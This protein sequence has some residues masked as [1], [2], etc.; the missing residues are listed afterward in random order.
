[1]EP[2]SYRR[3]SLHAAGRPARQHV[4]GYAAREASYLS[5]RL[6]DAQCG[7]SSIRAGHDFDATRVEVEASVF[8]AGVRGTGYRGTRSSDVGCRSRG[9]VTDIRIG[10]EHRDSLITYP[11]AP[12]LSRTTAGGLAPPIDG[13]LTPPRSLGIGPAHGRPIRMHRTRSRSATY[14]PT[15][16]RFPTPRGRKP[17]GA[18]PHTSRVPRT[19]APGTHPPRA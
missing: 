2:L 8:P 16:H 9:K 18:Q 11:D 3:I 17:S 7:A 10:Y 1:M 4:P 5:H 6:F 13:L 12:F 15:A 19:T 14:E